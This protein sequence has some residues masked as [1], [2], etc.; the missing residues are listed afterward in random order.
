MTDSGKS[1]FF[2]RK[3]RILALN[4]RLKDKLECSKFSHLEQSDYTFLNDIYLS[5]SKALEEVKRS[6]RYYRNGRLN[7]TFSAPEGYSWNDNTPYYYMR[8]PIFH[9]NSLD[10]LVIPLDWLS[11]Y[12]PTTP[13]I[14]NW[15]QALYLDLKKNSCI[16]KDI[17]LM[18]NRFYPCDYKKTIPYFVEPYR[19]KKCDRDWCIT[20]SKYPPRDDGIYFYSVLLLKNIDFSVLDAKIEAEGL[21]CPIYSDSSLKCKDERFV[22]SGRVSNFDGEDCSCFCIRCRKFSK[23]V[24][25][26][27]WYLKVVNLRIC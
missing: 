16:G 1:T 3:V 26:A 15:H 11:W 4:N 8:R 13:I 25:V 21:T 22:I 18:R 6:R 7:I 24:Y 20:Y 19:F 2:I 23:C 14:G 10:I 5:I 27:V 9:N 12:D 17:F